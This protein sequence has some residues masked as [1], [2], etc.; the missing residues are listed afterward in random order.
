MWKLFK[1][2]AA[3]DAIKEKAT[4]GGF[5][6][7]MRSFKVRLGFLTAGYDDKFF[8]W[9]I[10]LLARKSFLVVLIVFL[11]SV[12]S[13]VQSLAA[14]LMMT[15]FLIIQTR[16][17]PYYD[18]AL[19]RMEELSLTVIIVTIYF[20]LYY[21][22]GA[23]DPIMESE[24]VSWMIF[25]CVLSPSIAFAISFIKIMWIEVLKV[26]A[27][28]SAR[29]FRYLTCGSRNITEFKLQYFDD[30]ESD[31]NNASLDDDV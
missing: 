17:K 19:N 20:G 10:V 5:E 31:A 14:V 4:G 29:L 28:K 27:K 1:N 24:P 11:S 6:D 3:L 15:I 26:V 18:D 8:Y 22:A 9:E 23:G 2:V 30:D 7:L 13:G 21:Q 16:Y 12:S 25:V